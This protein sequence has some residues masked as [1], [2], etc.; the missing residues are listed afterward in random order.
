MKSIKK[1]KRRGQDYASSFAKVR[2]FLLNDNSPFAAS[3]TYKSARTH[4]MYTCVGESG[5]KKIVF[6][7]AFEHEGKTLTCINLGISLGQAGKRVLIIDADMRRPMLNNILELKQAQGLSEQLAGMSGNDFSKSGQISACKTIY[8]NV[9]VLPAGRTP[10]NPAELLSSPLMN[11]ILEMLE[12]HFDYILIDTPPIGEVTDTAVLIPWIH[13][14]IFVVRAGRTRIDGLK[15]S[16]DRMKQL[17]GNILGFILNDYDPKKGL[18][19]YKNYG[20]YY[21]YGKYGYYGSHSGY[22]KRQEG[23]RSDSGK[24]SD[25]KEI[26]SS[27]GATEGRS[28][29]TKSGI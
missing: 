20:K 15:M 19:G 25:Y 17:G 26:F 24:I 14:H 18:H 5:C 6:T 28:G 27:F 2:A 10:P 13:G 11:K 22:S 3:E 1:T 8:E 4:L 7:S 12:Q 21:K 23:T 29:E 16:V 9:T